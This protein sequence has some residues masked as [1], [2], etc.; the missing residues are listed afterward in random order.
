[1][2][3]SVAYDLLK[4]LKVLDLT[5]LL[6]GPFCSMMLADFGA[7]VL[8]IEAPGEGDYLRSWEPLVE[9]KSAF[10]WAVNRNKR[11]LTLN[12]KRDE[13]QKLFKKLL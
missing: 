7:E 8:K 2:S 10:F 9:G 6:P 12:L 11:S 3:D 5:R 4:G 1:M 13:G